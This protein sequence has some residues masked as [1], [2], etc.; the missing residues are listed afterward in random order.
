M[1]FYYKENSSI[2]KTKGNRARCKMLLPV[3]TGDNFSFLMC[4]I[5]ILHQRQNIIFLLL[6]KKR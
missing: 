3:K 1:I 6:D 4:S 2:L 5:R